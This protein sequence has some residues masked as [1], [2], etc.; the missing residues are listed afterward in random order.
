[1]EVRKPYNNMYEHLK[2]ELPYTAKAGLRKDPA[3]PNWIDLNKL[4]KDVP[5]SEI[6]EYLEEYE[7]GN[8]YQDVMKKYFGMV[9][10]I[11]DNVGKLLRFLRDAGLEEDTIVV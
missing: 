4:G 11:D 7:K 5:L 2:F 6:D 9:K 8:F 1:M 10:C 3:I